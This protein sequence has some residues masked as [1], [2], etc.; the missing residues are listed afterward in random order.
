MC[1]T[2]QKACKVAT[3]S[4]SQ[5]V[6]HNFPSVSKDGIIIKQF[7]QATLNGI[8]DWINKVSQAGNQGTSPVQ[9]ISKETRPFVYADKINEIIDAIHAI[10]PSNT[11][12]KVSRDKVIRASEF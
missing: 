12:T 5:I 8:I 7:S 3:Q 10:D 6:N 11:A 2:A 4:A 1:N 9:N